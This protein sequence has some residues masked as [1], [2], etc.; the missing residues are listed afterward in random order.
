MRLSPSRP[1]CL[2]IFGALL[3]ATS[4]PAGAQDK[5]LPG[6]EELVEGAA[7]TG[8]AAPAAE[9]AEFLLLP[10]GARAVGMGGA[11]TGMRGS[12]DLLLWNPAGVA[13][14]SSVALLVNHS[15]TAF[16]T[17]SDV[18]SLLWPVESVGTLGV[19]YYLVDYGELPSTNAE[20]AVHGTISFRNQEFVFTYAGKLIGGLEFGV[21]YKII[22]LVFR[23]D[24]LCSGQQSFTRTTHAVD[25]G[26][27]Y[28]RV[29][30]LPLAL[31]A[32]VRHL[33][34]ALKGASEEDPLPTRV[35]LGLAYHVLRPTLGESIFDLALALDV[36]DR[37][38]DLRGPDVMLGSELGV[39]KM[40]FLRAGY[41]FLDSGL[42]GPTL[43]LGLTHDWFFLDLS[44]GFDDV[45]A[46]TGDE[47]VQVTF[48]VNF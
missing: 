1:A 34:F 10:V 30:G 6:G 12:G 33:G 7:R 16:D 35:R 8:S 17:R 13:G 20:G 21:N 3:L 43:G 18:L 28:D 48:G 14:V 32:S 4:R 27:V 5:V 11:V 24:G 29:V 15:E 40:F 31:G 22:Q 39:A 38:R 41:A 36:E 23:C 19:T 37:W 42:G 25:L 44:R 45:T 2:A 9:G 26:L 46:A 47:A